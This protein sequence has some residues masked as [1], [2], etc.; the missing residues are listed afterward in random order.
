[1]AYAKALT[2]AAPD[3]DLEPYRGK[4]SESWKFT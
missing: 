2:A 1:V 3:F 4:P